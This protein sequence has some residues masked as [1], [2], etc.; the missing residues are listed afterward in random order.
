M[1]PDWTE[2]DGYESDPELRKFI[3]ENYILVDQLT[4]V[5]G[6]KPV[7]FFAR[8]QPSPPQ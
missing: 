7:P 1:W 6:A 4:L 3:D 2:N 8:R 5:K